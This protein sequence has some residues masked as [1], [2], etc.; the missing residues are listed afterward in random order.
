MRSSNLW[1]SSCKF[2]IDS[3][4]NAELTNNNDSIPSTITEKF[5]QSIR[6]I[7]AERASNKLKK[8]KEKVGTSKLLTPVDGYTSR[9]QYNGYLKSKRWQYYDDERLGAYGPETEE[10]YNYRLL[11]K[12]KFCVLMGFAGGNYYGMQYNKGVHTIEGV[13]LD[14]MVKNR[15]IL[16]EHIQK[17]WLIAFDR[18]S[19]TD[20]G[21]SAA[22]MNISL[23]LRKCDY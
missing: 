12:Q 11:K 1:T 3:L 19:R 21:V 15:W 22:R 7:Q 9:F 8:A 4:R 20:R 6:A 14:A 23:T 10:Q 17:P 13:L 5:T 16:S 18:G 2:C